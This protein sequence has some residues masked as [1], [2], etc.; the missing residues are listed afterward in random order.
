VTKKRKRGSEVSWRGGRGEE[1]KREVSEL[2]S[3]C[4]E[5]GCVEQ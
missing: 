5:R 1:Y 4:E 2:G 3:G